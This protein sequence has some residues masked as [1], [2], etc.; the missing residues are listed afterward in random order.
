MKL[1]LDQMYQ[2]HSWLATIGREQARQHA[3]LLNGLALEI[4]KKLKTQ[5]S[6]SY[7]MVNTRLP[8]PNRDGQ[9]FIK[10]SVCQSCIDGRR[11]GHIPDH[12][13]HDSECQYDRTWPELIEAIDRFLSNRF[14]FDQ[15][16]YEAEMGSFQEECRNEGKE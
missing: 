6:A 13:D 15:D 5:K 7:V 10:V 3:H 9:L 8:H 4:H 1:T 11:N 16:E 14:I 2:A 12:Q